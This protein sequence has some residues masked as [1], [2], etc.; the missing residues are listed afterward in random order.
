MRKNELMVDPDWIQ[1]LERESC[2]ARQMLSVA[3]TTLQT[4]P[5]AL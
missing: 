2:S 3:K 5:L 4:P 1:V